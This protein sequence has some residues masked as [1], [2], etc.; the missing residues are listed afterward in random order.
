MARL[1]I[2]MCDIEAL[3][4]ARACR[5]QASAGTADPSIYR[6]VCSGSVMCYKSEGGGGTARM[7]LLEYLQSLIVPVMHLHAFVQ[8]SDLYLLFPSNLRPHR[9]QVWG[10]DEK[11]SHV[12]S[13]CGFSPPMSITFGDHN[14]DFREWVL[15]ATIKENRSLLV[16]GRG[17]KF[18]YSNF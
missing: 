15:H 2:G 4:S 10:G 16:I 7:F 9:L 17:R 3:P 8:F 5:V 18:A 14:R 1:N 12:I 11:S 6:G 13:Q